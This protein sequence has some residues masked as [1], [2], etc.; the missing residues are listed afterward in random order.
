M[1]EYSG[2]NSM[3][4]RRIANQLSKETCKNRLG[5]YPGGNLFTVGQADMGKVEVSVVRRRNFTKPDD[6]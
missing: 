5:K 6:K 3:L 1:T 2:S 4:P